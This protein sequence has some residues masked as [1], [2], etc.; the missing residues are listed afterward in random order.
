MLYYSLVIIAVVLFGGCFALNDVY[1]KMRSS[2]L[3]ESM[4][5][6]F[7]G[8]VAGLA[9]LLPMGGFKPQFTLFTLLIALLSALNGMAYTFC[10]LKALERVNLSLYSLFA[11]LGGM[12]LPFL[13][14]IIFYDED[15]TLQKFICLA[16]IGGALALSISKEQRKG[17]FLWYAGIFVLNGMSGVLSKIFTD[18]PFAKTSTEWFSIWG[19]LLSALL[20]GILWL[21]LSRKDWNR[22]SWKAFGIAFANGGINRF[23][24]FL[25]VIALVHIDAS[26]QYP[27]ITGGVIIVSTIIC[28]LKKEKPKR[29]E[30]L[31]VA[32][33]FVG[34]LILAF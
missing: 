22:Y 6:G 11:M 16:L 13:Q 4:A 26:I 25:L 33:S 10:S 5:L 19:A 27:M 28:F 24:N 12:V 15:P 14:G 23:A 32:L 29:K 3:A 7:I 31:A 34:L 17:G 18:A 20:S 1:Q 2:S 21:I 8:S 30:L 9:I